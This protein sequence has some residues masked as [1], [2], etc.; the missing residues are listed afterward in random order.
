M[1]HADPLLP[2][3]RS[4]QRFFHA[5]GLPEILSG[6]VL[7]LVPLLLLVRGLL[8]KASPWRS[9][10]V[11]VFSALVIGI[12]V[13]SRRLLNAV[14]TRVSGP[15]AGFVRFA[16][17]DLKVHLLGLGLAAALVLLF[18]AVRAATANWIAWHLALT[19][20]TLS[21]FFAFEAR[22]LGL[23]RFYL[24]AALSLGLGLA[25][26]LSRPAA[27]G[28]GLAAYFS[29]MGAALIL[30]GA[31]TLRRF[32]RQAPASAEEAP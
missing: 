20:L 3:A 5:D 19:G 27:L 14:K 2:A 28:S 12:F 17:L 24:L 29:G 21:L 26:A 22:L 11:I 8:P 7:L 1:R 23:R 30:S 15:R 31:F 9:L 18:V 25:L 6:S 10:L 32:L 16:D 4:V 13:L